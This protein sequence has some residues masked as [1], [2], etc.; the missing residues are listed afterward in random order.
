MAKKPAAPKKATTP[1]MMTQAA[2]ARHRG[3]KRQTVG[4]W[5]TRGEI[6]MTKNSNGRPRVD[7]AKSD[8]LLSALQN[9]LKTAAMHP[10]DQPVETNVTPLDNTATKIATSREEKE[11]A[12]A[13]MSKLKYQKMAGN[14]IPREEIEGIGP[15]AAAM[16]QQAMSTRRE[17]LA[18]HL[19][20]CQTEREVI[21]ALR[22]DDFNLLAVFVEELQAFDQLINPTQDQAQ[23]A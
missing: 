18:R 21:A 22:Q 5:K 6:V 19:S 20:G 23:S 10:D 11:R 16:L 13:N 9:P 1:T 12:D 15:A 14:L 4:K 17:T 2:Y 8:A 7:V 3:V